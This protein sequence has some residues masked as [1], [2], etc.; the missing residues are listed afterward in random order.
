MKGADGLSYKVWILRNS[1][2]AGWGDAG[3]MYI[4]RGISNVGYAAS[5]VTYDNG[6]MSGQANAC[7]ATKVLACGSR[8]PGRNDQAGST[9]LTKTYACS[10]RSESGPEVTYEFVPSW[11]GRVTA[12]LSGLTADLDLYAQDASTSSCTSKTC[13][14]FGDDQ[15]TFQCEGRSAGLPHGWTATTAQSAT[16]TCPSSA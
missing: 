3:Y 10:T 11:D 16:S 8:V 7:S 14:G 15:V 6:G 4:K 13:L 1:W 5:Y 2:G 9:S 12:R